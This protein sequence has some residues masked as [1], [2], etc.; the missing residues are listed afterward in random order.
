MLPL[1]VREATPNLCADAFKILAAVATFRRCTVRGAGSYSNRAGVPTFYAGTPA[2]VKFAT[3][4][5]KVTTGDYVG[6]VRQSLNVF[7][8]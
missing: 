3:A 6:P 1:H 5:C 2:N 7:R 4:G 8:I